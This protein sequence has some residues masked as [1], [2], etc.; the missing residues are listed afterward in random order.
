MALI[1]LKAGRKI[2]QLR[3]NA[4]LTQSQLAEK[5]D[6][7]YNYISYVERG[8]KRATVDFYIS[9]AN[10]FQVALDE[11]FKDSIEIDR[12][13]ILDTILLKLSYIDEK[14]QKMFL[15]IIEAVEDMG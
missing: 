15:K 1:Y 14:K 9:A 3:I 8:K 6:C 11:I 5:L 2:K 12:N 10:F 13:I 7:S 4:G